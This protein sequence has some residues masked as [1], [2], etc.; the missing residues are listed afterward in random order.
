M[1]KS[2][3]NVT[4]GQTDGQTDGHEAGVFYVV[5]W[6]IIAKILRI[7]AKIGFEVV[8]NTT[9]KQLKKHQKKAQAH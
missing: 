2:R 4:G 6:G 9:Q 3:K 5:R 7:C 8:D 1:P